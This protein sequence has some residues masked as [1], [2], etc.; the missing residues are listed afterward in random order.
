VDRE[1]VR[2]TNDPR[3]HA[4]TTK[5]KNTK[6]SRIGQLGLLSSMGFQE[7]LKLVLYTPVAFRLLLIGD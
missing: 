3:I 6:L 5:G 4:K 1:L 7:A 2:N